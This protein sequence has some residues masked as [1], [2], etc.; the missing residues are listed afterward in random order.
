MRLV[1][2]RD[3]DGGHGDVA[4]T[5]EAAAAALGH[6]PAITVVA[7]TGR[8]EQG[9]ASLANWAAK[10]ANLL[11]DEL[12]LGPGDRLGLD[13][14]PGWTVAAVCLAAW[15]RGVAI[16]PADDAPQAVVHAARLAGR[17]DALVVGDAFDGTAPG[18]PWDRTW[19]GL[20]RLHPDR[21][22]RPERDGAAT[23]LV[24]DGAVRDQTGLLALARAD[25]RDVLGLVARSA[26]GAAPSVDVLA[27]TLARVALRPLVS[28]AATIVA[29]D[30]PRTAA[31][32][33]GAARWSDVEADRPG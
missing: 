12:G 1:G 7:P 32:G 9:V 6:R 20:A 30:E 24:V 11:A 10:G 21:P 23:A 2:R 5:L 33:E 14:P 18:V 8:A 17:A 4:S 25:G 29:L 3:P 31:A 27:L 19:T 13:V 16:V 15:W 28:G 26:A 22:P